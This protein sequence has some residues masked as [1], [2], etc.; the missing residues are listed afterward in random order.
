MLPKTVYSVILL[1]IVVKGEE[2]HCSKFDFE[3]KVLD[4][5]VR[6]EFEMERMKQEMQKATETVRKMNR[7]V[8]MNVDIFNKKKKEI[9]DQ[10][11]QL[12]NFKE[13]L[14][15]DVKHEFQVELANFKEVQRNP[16]A[17]KARSNANINVQSGQTFVFP[18]MILDVGG[19]YDSTSGVFTAPVNGTY[20]F[21]TAFCVLNQMGFV[22]AIM[23]NGKQHSATTTNGDANYGCHSSDTNA[24]LIAGQKV[25]VQQLLGNTGEI[26]I[27]SA[28]YR[29]N[30]FSGTLV[31][32]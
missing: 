5:M 21:T 14:S 27:H 31:K 24:V 2:P 20:L 32:A 19:G 28:H 30:T 4:K 26:I 25:W 18:I 6:M 8:E 9:D 23:V 7:Q 22:W 3:E 17:F 15:N 13:K 29:W 1:L 12:E 10:I 11:R 16:V